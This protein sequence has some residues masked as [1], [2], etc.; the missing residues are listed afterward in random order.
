MIENNIDKKRIRIAFIIVFLVGAYLLGGLIWLQV[1]EGQEY[2][3]RAAYN[4]LRFLSIPSTRGDMYDRNGEVIV[5]STSGYTI[6]VT[7][8]SAEQNEAVIKVLAPLMLN[9]RLKEDFLLIDD[10]D[11]I[12]GFEEEYEQYILEN[13]ETTLATLEENI[14]S[15]IDSQRYFRRYEPIKVAPISGQTIREVEMSVVAAVEG[16]RAL[17]PNVSVDVQP[18]RQYKLGDY[19]FHLIGSINQI[20][21]VGNE[22]LERSFD[23]L[24]SGTDG[25]KLVEVNVHGRPVDEI[26]I[27]EPISG[28]D[29]VLTLDSNLQRVAEDALLASLANTRNS[30]L[31]SDRN[32]PESMLPYSGAVIVMDVNTGE[33]LA[34]A[35]MPQVSRDNYAYY[36]SAKALENPLNARFTPLINKATNGLRPPGSIMKPLVGLAGLEEEIVNASTTVYCYGSYRG[37]SGNWPRSATMYCWHRAGHGGPIDIRAGL[38]NSCNIYFYPIGERLGIDSLKEYYDKFGFDRMVSLTNR[39][40]REREL[41]TLYG[42]NPM[43]ADL[44]QLAIGQGAL[45]VTPL[46]VVQFVSIIANAELIN[47]NTYVG[48]MYKPHI[49]SQ[50]ISSEGEVVEYYEPEVMQEIVMEK[51]ALDLIRGGLRDVIMERGGIDGNTGTGYWQF[52]QGNQ[53]IFPFEIAGKT[54]TSQETS[55][56]NHG[57]F[58]AYAPYDEPEIAVV[59]LMEQGR[60]GGTTG[61]PVAREIF[62]EYFS[63]RLD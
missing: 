27:I 13:R 37:L 12:E 20:D 33:I 5:N 4:S 59:V 63:D 11:S 16:S 54:G 8:T 46:Q 51:E 39:T 53:P 19:A 30:V 14:K 40:V 22:G 18:I 44:A 52:H 2:A 1:I 21:R 31:S 9:Q 25:R 48:N 55:W 34:S 61:G 41:F 3:R 7:Y 32:T 38:K 62:L 6:N 57:W 15:I 23:G 58:F 56:G 50:V 45:S 29:L 43:P 24:L 47:E 28:H 10:F 35:S 49:V 36:S 60:S 26:G 17:L 42:G